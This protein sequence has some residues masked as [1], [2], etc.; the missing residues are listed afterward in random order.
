MSGGDG[1]EEVEVPVEGAASRWSDGWTP[2]SAV[3]AGEEAAGHEGERGEGGEAVVLLAAGEGE[4]AE[5]EQRPEEEGESR[6]R[7]GG[8]WR[9]RG[10][11][12]SRM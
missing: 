9:D 3:G 8:R 5:D 7:A 10:G 6:L 12:G 2:E 4:E 11:A 1:D